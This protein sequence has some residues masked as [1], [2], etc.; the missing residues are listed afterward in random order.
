M[1]K[2]YAVPEPIGSG[3]QGYTTRADGER[4]NLANHNP[5]ARSPCVSEEADVEADE[6]DHGRDCRGVVLGFLAR[7]DTDDA[8]DE[9]HDDHT[10]GTNDEELA[11]TE[12]LN[13][14]E[15]DGCRADIDEGGDEGDQE[16]ILDRAEGGEED[17][18]EIEDEVDT[19]QLLHHLHQDACTI[20][21]SYDPRKKM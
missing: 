11:T 19:G 2:T 12:S 10:G 15:G 7:G 13:G 18:T 20:D 17:G 14:V 9:L 3:G 6:C 1:C 8:H 5:G 4:E 21:V 16:G